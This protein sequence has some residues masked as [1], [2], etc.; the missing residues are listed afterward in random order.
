[1]ASNYNYKVAE[2]D[3]NGETTTQWVDKMTITND[4]ECTVPPAE[5]MKNHYGGLFPKTL[6]P[7]KTEN[8]FQVKHGRHMT[9]KLKV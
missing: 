6:R 3:H 7:R 2:L 5:K 9:A 8:C 4:A 1:M